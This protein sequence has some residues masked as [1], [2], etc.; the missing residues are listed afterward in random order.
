MPLSPS[1]NPGKE[2]DEEEDEHLPIEERAS[3]SLDEFLENEGEEKEED[4]G[5]IKNEK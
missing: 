4:A 3:S 1:V 5:Y 2:E